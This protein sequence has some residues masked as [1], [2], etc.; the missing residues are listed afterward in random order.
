MEKATTT[1]VR[2]ESGLFE[3]KLGEESLTV[4]NVQLASLAYALRAIELK[5]VKTVGVTVEAVQP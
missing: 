2:L 5:W 4:S 1:I 3:L